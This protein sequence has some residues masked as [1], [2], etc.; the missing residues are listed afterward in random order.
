MT[1]LRRTL[2]CASRSLGC[3]GQRAVSAD[4]AETATVCCEQLLTFVTM[5]EDPGYLLPSL[6]QLTSIRENAAHALLRFAAHTKSGPCWTL[7]T[8][9]GANDRGFGFGGI[10]HGSRI[11]ALALERL[12]AGGDGGRA[13]AAV[14]AAIARRL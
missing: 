3:V 5:E 11:V 7:P 12:R 2:C 4:D 1:E 14:M 6:L 13:Q 8:V 9:V 10:G